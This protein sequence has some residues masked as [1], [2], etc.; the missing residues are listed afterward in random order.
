MKN[1]ARVDDLVLSF[2]NDGSVYEARKDIAIQIIDGTIY[3]KE[4]HK[5]FYP[6]VRDYATNVLG[7]M[8]TKFTSSDCSQAAK[9]IFKDTIAHV[10]E[11][12]QCG[13]KS[14]H[15]V[16]VTWRD[17]LYGNTYWSA[18][19]DIECDMGVMA[20]NMP[21]SYGDASQAEWEVAQRLTE[22]GFFDGD[23]Y[24]ARK[25]IN[26]RYAGNVKKSQMFQG[27]CI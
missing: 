14:V 9:Q 11:C 23:V 20:I 18:R 8:G 13:V 7:N 15:T 25:Q 26:P 24:E 3:G 19:V 12:M 5:F 16:I 1:S 21:M 10:I 2:M 6:M 22:L 4:L 17:D 27:S